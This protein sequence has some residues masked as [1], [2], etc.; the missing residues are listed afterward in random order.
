MILDLVLESAYF[1]RYN[2]MGWGGAVGGAI[3]DYIVKRGKQLGP[4]LCA[5]CPPA[6]KHTPRGNAPGSGGRRPS[7]LAVSSGS[8]AWCPDK[9]TQPAPRH[10][11]LLTRPRCPLVSKTSSCSWMPHV[12]PEKI[13]ALDLP[14]AGGACGVPPRRPVPT[15][16]ALA[17]SGDTDT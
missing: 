15:S 2:D 7:C 4:F 5:Q 9:H 10:T 12:K 8:P 17:G 13:Q 14:R 11:V 16:T 3:T 1:G 6:G